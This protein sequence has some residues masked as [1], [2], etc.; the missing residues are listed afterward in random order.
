MGMI[1][2]IV[3]KREGGRHDFSLTRNWTP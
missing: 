2:F 1:Y 3:D